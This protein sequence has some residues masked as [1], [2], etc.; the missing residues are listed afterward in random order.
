MHS[1]TKEIHSTMKETHSATTELH[2]ATK[3]THSAT[4]ELHS[5]TKETH[6]ATT[7]AH[8]ATKE[9]HSATLV[10]EH[11]S[12]C[13][14]LLNELCH[15]VTLHAFCFLVREC[16]IKTKMKATGLHFCFEI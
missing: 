3:E 7:E 11:I 10:V 1:A 16:E 13:R 2:A 6:S 14:G 8:S 15:F 5:A 12:T 9:T 4:T